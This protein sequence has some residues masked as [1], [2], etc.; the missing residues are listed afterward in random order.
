LTS[1]LFLEFLKHKRYLFL[2]SKICLAWQSVPSE[3]KIHGTI[4]LAYSSK[5]MKLRFIGGGEKIFWTIFIS[6]LTIVIAGESHLSRA[7]SPITPAKPVPESTEKAPET[8]FAEGLGR[9]TLV[10]TLEGQESTPNAVVFSPDS[11]LVLA[12]GSDTDPLLRIWSVQTGQKIS[13][14]RAQ[15]TSVKALA[16]SPSERLLVSSGLDGSLNF[17]DIVAGKYLGV[18]LEHGNTV[19]ALTVTPDGKILISG[20]LEGIRLWTVQPPRRPLY[21]LN[22]VG[23]FVY[24]LGMNPDGVTLAS[25]HEDG[26]V[27]LWDIRE[28]KLIG[29]FPAH[30]QTVTK[31][32]YTPDGKNLIT[33]ST[34][35]TIKIWD[36]S[37]NKLL[38]TLTGHSARIR[39]L[40]LHPNGQVLA[41]ASNDGVR[42]WDV[43]T[44][45]Q[46]AWFDNQ[47]DWVESLAFSP[48][49]QYLASGNY[50]FKIRLWQL[51]R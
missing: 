17:W 49:G 29:K 14:T 11:Q 4:N 24:S 16:I 38:F 37:N 3:A 44:G 26:E 36:T 6:A 28:G 7:Q 32:L 23:N 13:Q 47:S 20:G 50:D 12:G 25:G 8:V 46:L 40:A 41:S 18:A 33:G 31:L 42:L 43:S 10:K 19:L 21:R 1:S 51:V 5:F 27:K 9:I 2:A 35:R 30:P 45:K 15:R 34:D 48:D 22:W 39:S